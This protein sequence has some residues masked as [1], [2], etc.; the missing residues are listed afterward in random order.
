M[1]GRIILLTLTAILYASAAYADLDSANNARARGDYAAAAAEYQRLAEAGDSV[2]QVNLG[3]M[4]YVGEG[5][6]RDYGQTIG[7]YTEAANQGNADAQYN[8]AVAY[9]FGEGVQQNFAAALKWY[10]AA[11]AQGHAVA[12]YSLGLSYSNGEGVAGQQVSHR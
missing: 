8:L 4:Y 3:Y 9:A 1:P 2:A 12:Q 6:T 10:Q 11:A 7:W 5:V